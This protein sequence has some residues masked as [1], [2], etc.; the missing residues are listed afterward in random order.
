MRQIMINWVGFG[1][2]Q[3]GP[4]QGEYLGIYLEGLTKTIKNLNEDTCWPGQD[5]NGTPPE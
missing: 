2:K 5:F 4:N 1:R 3:S